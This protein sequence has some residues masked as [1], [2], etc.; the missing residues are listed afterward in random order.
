MVVAWNN[1]RGSFCTSREKTLLNKL[2]IVFL[3]YNGDT[4]LLLDGKYNLS[5]LKPGNN[6]EFFHLGTFYAVVVSATV[7]RYKIHEN[8]RANITR[9]QEKQKRDWQISQYFL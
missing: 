9:L 4:V 8:A 6:N 1:S 3:L 7:V 5:K 2:F